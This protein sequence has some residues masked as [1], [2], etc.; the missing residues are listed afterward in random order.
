[1]IAHHAQA[2]AMSALVP[3]RTTRADLQALAGRIDATQREEIARMERWLEARSHAAGDPGEAHA[4]APTTA[5]EGMPGMLTAVELQQLEQA[6]GPAFER[7][8]LQRM[9]T[10]HEGALAMAA[11]LLTA[12]GGRDAE[13]FMLVSDIDADQRAEIARMR[14]LLDSLEP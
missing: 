9:I 8:F 1:M 3:A 5:H 2:L 10:H 6:S 7:L 11:Q 4:H 14:K 13:L 12:G